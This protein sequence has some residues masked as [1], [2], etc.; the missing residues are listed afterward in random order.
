MELVEGSNNAVT[1]VR[2]NANVGT[3]QNMGKSAG[4][5]MYLCGWVG[6]AGA[7][8]G[9]GQVFSFVKLCSFSGVS[10]YGSLEDGPFSGVSN[11]GRTWRMGPSVA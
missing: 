1:L 7:G 5:S 6:G 8:G 2:P 10:N 9:G 3:A 4:G 11:Y